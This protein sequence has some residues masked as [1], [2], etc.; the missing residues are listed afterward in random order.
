[1]GNKP[2]L[3]GTSAQ[4]AE[5]SKEDTKKPTTESAPDVSK[6]Y[7]EL[8]GSNSRTIAEVSKAKEKPSKPVEEWKEPATIPKKIP[9]MYQ[10]IIKQADDPSDGGLL[11]K[12]QSSGIFL[13]NKKQK[14][15]V[16][17]KSG[18]NCFMLFAR[19]LLITWSENQNF[20][21]WVSLKE[22]GDEEIEIASLLNVCWLEVHGRFETSYLTP[23]IMYE[24]VFMVMMEPGYGWAKPVNLRL[25]LPNGYVKQSELCLIE[26]PKRQW[27]E[28][29][30]GEFMAESNLAGEMEFSLYEYEGGH[31][32]RGLTIKGAVIRPKK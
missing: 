15:W 24:V 26:I 13:N 23:G 28:L 18:C 21:Q 12:I 16:E 9:H 32:K 8:V 31:W 10:A 6:T 7:E 1:M 17:K 27:T 2:S 20:W 14:Y 11:D 4:V 22:T 29:K 25:R 5:V 3:E 19:G 30:V